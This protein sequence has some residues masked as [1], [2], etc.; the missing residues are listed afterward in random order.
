[1][2]LV[3]FFRGG[4]GGGWLLWSVVGVGVTVVAV[5]GEAADNLW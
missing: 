4:V 3:L 5:G 1:M 2:L